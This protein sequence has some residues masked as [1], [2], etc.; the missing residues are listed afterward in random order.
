MTL[1]FAKTCPGLSSAEG[2]R[3]AE[4]IH[5]RGGSVCFPADRLQAC[6]DADRVVLEGRRAQARGETQECLMCRWTTALPGCKCIR[7]ASVVGLQLRKLSV[8]WL[9]FTS[10]VLSVHAPSPRPVL[11]PLWTFLLN[12]MQ[13]GTL[14]VQEKGQFAS[15][16]SWANLEMKHEQ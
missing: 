5:S 2:R 14:S 6:G 10:A 8:V 13:T 7:R 12:N 3:A 1:V 4:F 15:A 9:V 11:S 16:L